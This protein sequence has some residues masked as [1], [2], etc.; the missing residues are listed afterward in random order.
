MS[1]LRSRESD[2]QLQMAGGVCCFELLF[3]RLLLDVDLVERDRVPV[4]LPR[5]DV[6]FERLLPVL[7]LRL[8]VERLP[9]FDREPLDLVDLE[10]EPDDF[11][12][13]CDSFAL[14]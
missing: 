8:E 7:L 4:L 10:R 3:P 2:F 11:V 5:V 12:A 13:T 1:S 14:C 9:L 6:D